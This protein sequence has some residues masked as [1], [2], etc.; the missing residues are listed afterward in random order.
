MKY[1]EKT[2]MREIRDRI[3]LELYALTKNE[4]SIKVRFVFSPKEI[5]LL[6]LQ[7]AYA[8]TIA[9]STTNGGLHYAWIYFNMI[10]ITD[11]IRM[12]SCN[13]ETEC[14]IKSI[15][16][17]E[18]RHYQQFKEIEEIHGREIASELKKALEEDAEEYMTKLIE[19]KEQIPL[20]KV[21][22]KVQKLIRKL[23]AR[24][25]S[26]MNKLKLV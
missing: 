13:E 11:T 26:N 1:Y 17:H 10:S 14:I 25:K 5:I 22:K 15:V 21:R 2:Y 6:N 4:N 9:N 8:S 16:H 20:D 7:Y 23:N 3:K 12:A 19:E 18:Y 24:A